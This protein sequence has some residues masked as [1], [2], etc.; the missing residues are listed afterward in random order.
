[1]SKNS[2]TD[3]NKKVNTIRVYRKQP[4]ELLHQ[5]EIANTLEDLQKAVGGYIETVTVATD[6]VIICNEEGKIMGLPYNVTFCG[7]EFVG[8]ILFAGVKG[9]EF[10]DA[11]EPDVLLRLLKGGA[12]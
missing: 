8:T 10:A 1:M 9:D 5:I 12:R 7:T 3:S 4:G 6:L 11:P 2:I